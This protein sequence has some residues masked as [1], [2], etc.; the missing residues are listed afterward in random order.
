LARTTQRY[1]APV[2]HKATDRTGSLTK[3]MLRHGSEIKSCQPTPNG[4]ATTG[5]GLPA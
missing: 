1:Y 2:A 4:V 5:V 3:Y